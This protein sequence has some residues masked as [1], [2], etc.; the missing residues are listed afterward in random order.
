MIPVRGVGCLQEQSVLPSISR[1]ANPEGPRGCRVEGP[2]EEV[3][4]ERWWGK[5]CH[6]ELW[7]ILRSLW[8][9]DIAKLGSLIL[10]GRL[11]LCSW[12]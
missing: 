3:Y 10:E 9:I 2:S 1:K 8:V 5:E 7:E 4:G 12:A 11:E 6:S